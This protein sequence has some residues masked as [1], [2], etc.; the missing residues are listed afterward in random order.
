MLN[1][2]SVSSSETEIEILY[3]PIPHMAIKKQKADQ[4]NLMFLSLLFQRTKIPKKILV[5][6][7]KMEDMAKAFIFY[8]LLR[9]VYFSNQI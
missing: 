9:V 6:T 3:P 2:N 1:Q 4:I 5:T 8:Y 7:I